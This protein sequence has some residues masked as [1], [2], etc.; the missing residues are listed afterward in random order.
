MRLA[1]V[2]AGISG[3]G[4][5]WLL[6]KDN[7]VDIYES[8]AALGGHA[9]TVDLTSD[10]VTFPTDAGFQVFN[11]R[12]YPNLL[13]FF[14][15]LDIK[16][17]E[18][19]MSF[20]VR[21]D[22]ENIEWSGTSLNSVFAQRKN[23]TNP[24]FLR[25]LADVVRFSRDADRLLA[26][27]TIDE[28]TLGQL[29]ERE[30]YSTVFTDWYLIPMGDAIWSTPPGKMLDYPAATFLHF[31]DN[32]GL[33]HITG[34]PMW[35][36]VI[37]GS[38]TYVERAARSFSGE[39]HTNE[40]AEQIE[41]TGAGVKI[42]TARRVKEYDAVVIAAHA[43]DTLRLLG[44]GAT[45]D[46]RDVLSAFSYQPNPVVLHTDTAFMPQERR[47]WA[48]WNWYAASGDS[49]K[50]ALVLT[51]WINNLQLLPS[52]VRPVME[53]LNANRPFAEGTVLDR[54]VFDHPLFTTEA[55]HAQ[56]RVPAL[57]GVG[58]V[59]FAGAWQRY[60]FHEDGLLSGVRVAESLGAALPWAG[61][62]DES[63]TKELGGARAP[64]GVP[65]LEPGSE[66]I[67]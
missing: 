16:H 12:T 43:P 10:G 23:V 58:G 32:H 28:L 19:D 56:R 66:G 13:R 52:K 33:L 27:P 54:M 35:M 31:C 46:E 6:S 25:M 15:R 51:Y 42:H 50:D 59:W 4:A 47:A 53:T 40:P 14:E 64:G 65:V 44:D 22:S 30:G 39:V 2:G 9:R 37:G 18:T 61:E 24:R 67:A 38:R 1:I 63:R 60:G 29:L 26:D 21:V 20:S 5:A 49:L 8:E 11:Q 7:T 62:L 17:S 45:P 3:I 48:S 34:K 36:S 57:Q 41:R 55:I